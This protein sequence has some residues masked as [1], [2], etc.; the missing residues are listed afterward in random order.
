M[1]RKVNVEIEIVELM[2]GVGDLFPG[3]FKLWRI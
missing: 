2:M 3:F 1:I